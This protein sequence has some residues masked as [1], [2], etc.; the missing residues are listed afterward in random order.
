[1]Y[2]K[3]DTRDPRGPGISP[4]NNSTFNKVLSLRSSA[5]T[6]NTRMC[7]SANTQNALPLQPMSDDDTWINPLVGLGPSDEQYTEILQTHHEWSHHSVGSTAGPEGAG[8]LEKC[9]PEDADHVRRN[10]AWFQVME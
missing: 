3:S 9:A 5:S 7:S 1:M 10:K 4:L 6:S 2:L 8:A